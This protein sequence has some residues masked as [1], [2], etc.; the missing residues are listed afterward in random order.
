M[1]PLPSSKTETTD[2]SLDVDESSFEKIQETLLSQHFKECKEETNINDGASV[3]KYLDSLLAQEFTRLTIQEREKSYEELHG[4][5][6]AVNETPEFVANSL[7][8][9]DL[10]LSKIT[11][12]DAYSLAEKQNSV[13][14]TNA[15][16]RLSFLRTEHFDPRKAAKRLVGFL[17]GKL[18][19][20]GESLLTQRIKFSD[21]DKD[22]QECLKYGQMQVLPARDR[23][24][25]AIFCNVNTIKEPCYKRPMNK[26]KVF[27]YMLL[28]LA[29][30]EENQ[31][32]GIVCL[33]MQMGRFNPMEVN[34]ELAQEN[35]RLM[36][37]IPL[38][39][40]AMHLCCDDPAFSLL[41]KLGLVGSTPKIRAR[42]RFHI[43]S[44]TE[45][46]YS[47]MTFGT[48]VGL[49]PM[50]DHNIIKKTNHNRW[51]ARRKVREHL[52]SFLSGSFSG[53]DLPNC[54][55][56]LLG[57]GKPIQHHPGNIQLRSLVENHMEEYNATERGLK[58][59]VIVKVLETVKA[60]SGR[61]LEKDE[62]GWWQEVSEH[63]AKGKI[64]KLFLTVGTKLNR[65]ILPHN[66][67]DIGERTSNSSIFQPGKRQKEGYGT[68][69][70]SPPAIQ[71]NAFRSVL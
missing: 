55:D 27:I 9:L 8:A 52:T 34:T 7:R 39:F 42:H 23:G 58:A 18:H 38:R 61:F 24:G 14:V 46:M 47:L 56:V 12:K 48:P 2:R 45:I 43:Q 10:E 60:A 70:A 3:D 19:Y 65:T 21:L 41:F 26:L 31:K 20:F 36:K 32:R 13:Y 29:E 28:T 50:N 62:H 5:D 6:D 57:K 11:K 25:R 22:D 16:F 1:S 51:I 49:F 59:I 63:D 67:R 40:S 4:V 66:E 35:P 30:D 53:T 64:A 54:H 71:N 33:L 15:K 68:R 44:H 17:E 37:W 69:L